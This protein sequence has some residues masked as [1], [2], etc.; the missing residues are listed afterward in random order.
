MTNRHDRLAARGQFLG[1]D[2]PSGV[3]ADGDDD[4]VMRDAIQSI[5]RSQNRQSA[6]CAAAL[7]IHESDRMRGLARF[8]RAQ[9][10]VR[11]DRALIPGSDDDDF[12]VANPNQSCIVATVDPRSI[13][14]SSADIGDDERRLVDEVLSSGR[15]AT[16]PMLE[17]FERAC[18]ERFGS[19]FAVGVSNGTAGLHLS[20]IAAGVCERDLVITTPFSFI[21]SAN[22]ILYERA[23]PVFVDI[24][25]VS[26]TMD[27]AAAIE[28]MEMLVHRRLGWERLLPGRGAAL[29]GELRAVIPVDLFGRVAEMGDLVAAARR[30][31]IAVIE[32]ACE[33]VGASLDGVPAGR[34]GDA[35]VFAFYPNKQMTTGEGGIVLTDDEAWA[36]LLYSLR[37]HGRDDGTWLRHER[38][39]Y[40][41]RLDELSA[42]V[43]LAQLRRL[44]ELLARRARVAAMYQQRVAAIDGVTTLAPPRG[45][46]EPSWFVYPVRLDPSIDRDALA[47]RLE[48]RGVPTRP[49]FWPIHLQTFYRQR[50]GYE[51]GM[52][53]H[54]EAAGDTLL[55]LPFHG[56][57]PEEDV[58]YVCEALAAEIPATR[59]CAAAGM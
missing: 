2:P 19:R 20:L 14:F 4:A 6:E 49:Y 22:P 13:A 47:L 12:H 28:A 43:G 1:T 10:R 5:E 31:G 27:A 32:D 25:P 45:G 8:V 58:D 41:Y 23:I 18:A 48:S 16:G 57:L 38:L 40:N 3:V 46:M 44:D 50:F 53:P 36:R 59:G 33:A 34:W 9:Q 21:A 30:L 54:S 39:G 17:R 35:G 42:A 7:V 56:R 24:D 26:L 55:A 29:P 52:Y 11:D 51:R 37:S 15:L